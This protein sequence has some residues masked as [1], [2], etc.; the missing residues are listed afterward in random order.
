MIDKETGE[1][2]G[3]VN[4]TQPVTM[5]FPHTPTAVYQEGNPPFLRT[6]YNYDMSKASDETGLAC[7]DKTRTQQQFKEE[8]DINTIVDRFGITGEMPKDVRVPVE[9]DYW[10]LSDYQAALNQVNAGREAFM[11]LPAKIRA[12]F[13]NDPGKLIAFI[14]DDTNREKAKKMGILVPEKPIEK[15]PEPVTVRVVKEDT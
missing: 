11:E 13:D 2:T 10:E 5:G 4:L 1:I 7:H 6:P 3:E 9:Q 14:S 12:E 15:P 8:T